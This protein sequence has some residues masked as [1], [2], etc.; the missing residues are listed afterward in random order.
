MLLY[1]RCLTAFLVHGITEEM[2]E[3][4]P[5]FST[6]FRELFDWIKQCVVCVQE[7]SCK[8]DLYYPGMLLVHWP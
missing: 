2:L 4:K 5:P 6:A 1:I 3:G 7:A 8:K